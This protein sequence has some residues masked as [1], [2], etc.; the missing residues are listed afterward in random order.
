MFQS[1]IALLV[2][3]AQRIHDDRDNGRFLCPS[4]NQPY[5]P[6]SVA[7]QMV[8]SPTIQPSSLGGA[9]TREQSH[10]DD[11]EEHGINLECGNKLNCY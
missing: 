4:P 11:I 2:R 5:P 1:F 6:Y 7:G 9:M 3:E 8:M 10:L